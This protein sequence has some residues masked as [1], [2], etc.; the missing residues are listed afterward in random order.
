MDF[1]YP[2]FNNDMWRVMGL[3]FFGDK[4]HFIVPGQKA[5]DKS[6][7]VDFLTTQGIAIG[8][9]AREVIRKKDNASDAFLEIVTPTRIEEVLAKLPACNTVVVTGQKSCE[10][11]CEQVD[12]EPPSIGDFKTFESLGR[13]I[14]LY[15]MPSTSRAYPLALEKKA[16]V[17]RRVFFS[18]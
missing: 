15:R 10:T 3:L 6:K 9:M 17:Y 5:F 4:T 16:E 13:T 2:N 8:D 14:R 18:N 1:F 7:L 12:L 11:L